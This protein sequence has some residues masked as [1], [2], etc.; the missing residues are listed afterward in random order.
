MAPPHLALAAAAL[1]ISAG[2]TIS[3]EHVVIDMAQNNPGDPVGW[4]HSKW[5]DPAVL[6]AEGYTA[7]ATTGEVV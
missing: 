6:K 4:Q 2:A 7:K 3:N 1:A 5:Q